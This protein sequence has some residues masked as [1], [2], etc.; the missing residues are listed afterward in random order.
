VHSPYISFLSL[1]P[2]RGGFISINQYK[3]YSYKVGKYCINSSSPE[4]VGI[5]LERFMYS[6]ILGLIFCH[7]KNLR[8]RDS[9]SQPSDPSATCRSV[10]LSALPLPLSINYTCYTRVQTPSSRS[11]GCPFS[12]GYPSGTEQTPSKPCLPWL[13]LQ[14]HATVACSPY[15]C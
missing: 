7:K 15:I 4:R 11:L 9:N 12:W 5:F 14:P 3:Q 6:S 8:A 13:G 1:P 2:Q 10:T